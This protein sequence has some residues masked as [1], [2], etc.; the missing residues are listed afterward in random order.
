M[1]ITDGNA[2]EGTQAP[3]YTGPS[4][5]DLAQ[6]VVSGLRQAG[7]VPQAAQVQAEKER[8]GKFQELLERLKA[9]EDTD[10]E[11]VGVWQEVGQALFSDF[12]EAGKSLVAGELQAERANQAMSYI[13][14]KI[15]AHFEDDEDKSDLIELAQLRLVKDVQSNAEYDQLKDKIARGGREHKALDELVEKH[16]NSVRRA[17]KREAG[18]KEGKGVSGITSGVGV[19]N[20]KNAKPGEVTA[21]FESLSERQQEQYSARLR[22]CLSTGYPEAEA[23]KEAMRSALNIPR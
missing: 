21:K 13:Q 23:Q 7:M 19:G 10:Q 22:S 20:V 2:I 17:L 14:S 5:A 18:S 11:Q 6:A 8:K 3:A 16:V 4:A 9:S 15:E 12:E 1:P